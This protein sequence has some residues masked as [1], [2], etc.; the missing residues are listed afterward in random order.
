MLVVEAADGPGGAVRTGELTVPGY[1]HDLFSAF[2]P[3]GFASPVLSRLHL[4]AYGLRWLRATLVIAN[5][6]PNGPTAVLSEDIDVT[7]SLDAFWS[8][9]GDGWRRLYDRLVVLDPRLV[10]AHVAVPSGPS[11]CCACRPGG[12]SQLHQDP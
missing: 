11:R 12:T 3:L 8:G 6:T 5:P 7:A 2:Y 1:H 4:E 10:Q 9:D